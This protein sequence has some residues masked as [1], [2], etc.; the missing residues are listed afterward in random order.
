MKYYI[1][2]YLQSLI[3]YVIEIILFISTHQINKHS[4][5]LYTLIVRNE[6][7][8]WVFSAYIITASKNIDIVAVGLK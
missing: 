7:D 3:F 5:L 6:Y 8:S 2:K 4:Q 1:D